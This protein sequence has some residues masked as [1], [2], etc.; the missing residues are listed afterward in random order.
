VELRERGVSPITINSYLRC[1]TTAA[2]TCLA[3]FS[4]S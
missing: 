3:F 4:Q 1:G 2:L